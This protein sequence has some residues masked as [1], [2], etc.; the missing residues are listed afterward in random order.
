MFMKINKLVS[1]LFRHGTVVVSAD[2]IVPLKTVAHY[3]IMS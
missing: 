2:T 3:V 1:Q